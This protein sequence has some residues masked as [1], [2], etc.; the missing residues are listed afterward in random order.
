M[1]SEHTIQVVDSGNPNED[2]LVYRIDCE[3]EKEAVLVA[4][5]QYKQDVG[6]RRGSGRKITWKRLEL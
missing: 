2:G 5:Q 4:I 1:I 6:L 3:T